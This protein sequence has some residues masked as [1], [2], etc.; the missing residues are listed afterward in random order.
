MHSTPTTK[1]IFSYKFDSPSSNNI[2]QYLKDSKECGWF[3]VFTHYQKGFCFC[4]V[5]ILFS[6]V[7]FCDRQT[8]DSGNSCSPRQK[9]ILVLLWMH[10]CQSSRRDGGKY[11]FYSVLPFSSPSFRLSCSHL[12]CTFKFFCWFLLWVETKSIQ[13]EW[14]LRYLLSE[15]IH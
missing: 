1:R 4:F 10:V 5:F 6:S 12:L 11:F 3:F 9:L 14:V 2:S 15:S 7:A 13:H 8:A